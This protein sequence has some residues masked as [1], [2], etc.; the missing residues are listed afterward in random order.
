[1]DRYF[2][3]VSAAC[4]VLGGSATRPKLAPLPFGFESIQEA[5][6]VFLGDSPLPWNAPVAA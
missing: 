2:S 3:I 4:P 1:M 6:R 5:L